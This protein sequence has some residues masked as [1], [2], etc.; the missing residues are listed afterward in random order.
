M[1]VRAQTRAVME[2]PPC[3]WDTPRTCTD[4]AVQT[5][6]DGGV[7]AIVVSEP[8]GFDRIAPCATSRQGA[9]RWAELRAHSTSD[10][11]FGPDGRE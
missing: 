6:R 7:M 8:D 10:A 5:A 2:V 1:C 3:L 11:W 4:L 9:D